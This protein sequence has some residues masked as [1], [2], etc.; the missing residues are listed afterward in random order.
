ML[1]PAPVS[2]FRG[3]DALKLGVPAGPAVGRAL[4]LAEREWEEAGFPDD[5]EA[6]AVMLARAAKA[7]G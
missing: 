6:A 3:A 2:P 7:A 4:A 5:A 1:L